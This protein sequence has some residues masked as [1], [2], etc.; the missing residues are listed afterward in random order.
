MQISI[1]AFFL[2]PGQLPIILNTLTNIAYL[3]FHIIFLAVLGCP[4]FL[5]NISN[6]NQKLTYNTDLVPCHSFSLAFK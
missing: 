2:F 6:P 1:M 5:S 4:F 3:R